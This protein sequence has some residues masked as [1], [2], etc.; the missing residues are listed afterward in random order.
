M[1]QYTSARRIE[2]LLTQQFGNFPNE[3]MAELTTG[4][5]VYFA[6]WQI[7]LYLVKMTSGEHVQNSDVVAQAHYSSPRPGTSLITV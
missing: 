1:Y 5:K 6:P 7:D 3:K 4:I 2:R